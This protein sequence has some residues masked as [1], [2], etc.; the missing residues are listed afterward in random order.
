MVVVSAV[1][2][3]IAQ[4]L[5]TYSLGSQIAYNAP[6]ASTFIEKVLCFAC[7]NS[8]Y[9]VILPFALTHQLIFAS[10]KGPDENISSGV[11]TILLALLSYIFVNVLVH[12][13]PLLT[14]INTLAF[15]LIGMRIFLIKECLRAY[16]GTITCYQVNTI[17][18]WTEFL[19]FTIIAL[20][21]FP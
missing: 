20:I 13:T 3:V 14:T 6:V 8:Y 7:T 18:L 2:N 19:I 9:I 4:I 10:D 5:I 1:L 11:Y 12:S 15:A 17:H 21:Y 16:Q